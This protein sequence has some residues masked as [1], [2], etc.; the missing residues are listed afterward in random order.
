[1]N[2][3][4]YKDKL[5]EYEIEKG[6]RKNLYIH[7]KDG[8]VLVK[9]PNRFP[10]Y[11]IE[12]FVEEK[13]EWIYIKLTEHK[14]KAEQEY[15]GGETFKVL[16]KDCKL[17]IVYDNIKNPKLDKIENSIFAFIPIKYKNEI[18]KDE[19]K[20]KIKKLIDKYYFN[21]AQV[22]VEKAMEKIT[23]IVGLKPKEYKVKNLKSVWGNC[24]S[25]KNIS[26]NKN[27]VKYRE[28]V[29]EYICLHEVCH[30]KHMNHSKDFWNMVFFYM[31][32][33]KDIEKELKK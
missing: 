2:T 5:I 6:K 10:N 15:V 12:K 27:I 21:L 24:S 19:E 33:Y 3:L 26:I 14:E 13:I 23:S 16:G 8:K 18:N 29:I 25:K 11:K 17:I 1:M 31:S 22:E 30:L 4:K 20:E 7:I 9:S 28:K 32:D